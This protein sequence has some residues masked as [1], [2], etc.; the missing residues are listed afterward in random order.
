METRERRL[1]VIEFARVV[2]AIGRDPVELFAKA[3]KRLGR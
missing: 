3:V 2:K 1:D